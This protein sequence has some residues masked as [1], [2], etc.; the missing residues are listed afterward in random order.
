MD[1]SAY[2]FNN[3][4]ADA[5]IVWVELLM[6]GSMS[7]DVDSN[8]A[9]F[10]YVNV[11]DR[12][13]VLLLANQWVAFKTRAL[14]MV[15]LYFSRNPAAAYAETTVSVRV[16]EHA[17]PNAPVYRQHWFVPTMI[18]VVVLMGALAYGVVYMGQSCRKRDYEELHETNA[19]NA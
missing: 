2:N 9:F 16:R 15:P 12:Q 8:G 3:V 7:S 18:C 4:S 14:A 11:T 1:L 5:S 13:S 10:D 17:P 19:V 6:N